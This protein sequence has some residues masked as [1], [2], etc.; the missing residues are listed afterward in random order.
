MTRTLAA[1]VVLILLRGTTVSWEGPDS[2]DK[3]AGWIMFG[4]VLL[5][6]AV[7]ALW[8]WIMVTS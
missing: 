1:L 2:N 4:F 8:I 5:I 6:L 7:V 3:G